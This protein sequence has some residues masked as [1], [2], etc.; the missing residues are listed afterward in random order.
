[1]TV[2]FSRSTNPNL[3]VLSSSVRIL[4]LEIYRLLDPIIAYLH[5]SVGLSASLKL[6]SDFSLRD[7]CISCVIGKS[8]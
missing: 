5:R 4:P 7:C 1:M 6:S 2:L 8:F 3:H